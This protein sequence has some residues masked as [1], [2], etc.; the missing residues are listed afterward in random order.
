MV[1]VSEAVQDTKLGMC[2]KLRAEEILMHWTWGKKEHV[3]LKR[4]RLPLSGNMKV[5]K[6]QN[7]NFRHMMI[8]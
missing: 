8:K 4:R 7:L 3:E 2:Y 1:A 6:E 5:T